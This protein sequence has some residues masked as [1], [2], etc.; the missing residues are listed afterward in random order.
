YTLVQSPTLMNTS[1]PWVSSIWAHLV[2]ENHAQG[3]HG[4]RG[5]ALVVVHD[6]LES[7]LGVVK[8]RDWTSSHRGHNGI[9]SVNSALKKG[10]FPGAMFERVGVGIG[11]PEERDARN[12]ASYVLGKM[13]RFQM[14]VVQEKGAE[15]V[16]R[17]LEELEE[18]WAV[19]AA[20]EAAKGGGS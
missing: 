14:D 4:T 3:A 12:V 7:E 16:L 10:Q 2:T 6:E 15:G 19:K 11:R 18:K 20:K 13:S 9:K 8:R 1:G 5:L 17:C